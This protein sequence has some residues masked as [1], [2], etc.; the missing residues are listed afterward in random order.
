MGNLYFWN[1]ILVAV[2]KRVNH[3]SFITWF[4]PISFLDLTSTQL[5]VEVPDHVFA[6]WLLNNYREVFEESLEEVGLQGRE[7]V[8]QV[9]VDIDA[10]YKTNRLLNYSFSNENNITKEILNSQLNIATFNSPTKP[11]T[12]QSVDS[13]LFKVDLNTKYIF[14]TFVVGSSNQ[15][16][17]AAAQAVAGSPSKTYNPLYIYGGVGLGKTH[18]MHAIGHQV[19]E[20]NCHLKLCY[21][22]VEKFMNELINAI[23]Y[24]QT[25]S[26][27]EKYRSIDILLIDHIQFM[28]GK[29]RNQD[30]FFH[31]FN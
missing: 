29:E 5:I 7:L 1:S 14:D 9:S 10:S 18:L 16:A 17:H 23:R 12:A 25:M 27:R 20:K 2:E 31:T 26:F 8:F 6:D 13:D 3:E 4:K 30:R 28:E 19:R 11:V 24:D 15:F 22:S 21:I